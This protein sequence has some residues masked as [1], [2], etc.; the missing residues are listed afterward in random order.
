MMSLDEFMQACFKASKEFGCDEA[1]IYY[2]AENRVMLGVL[3]GNLDNYGVYNES[4]LNL[5]VMYNRRN[6]YAY[7]EVFEDAESL[8]LHAM[9]NAMAIEN[10]DIHPLQ[11]LCAYPEVNEK[12]NPVV[13]MTDEEKLNIVRNLEADIKAFDDRVSRM[14][15]CEINSGVREIRIRNTRGLR[16]DR[17]N[18][19]SYVTVVPIVSQGD[20]ERSSYS[21]KFGPDI[22]DYDDLVKECVDN[23]LILFNAKPV[24]SGEYRVLLRADAASD[25]MERFCEVF[26]AENVQEGLSMLAGK[27]NKSIAS[28]AV[29]IVDDPFEA[30][31]P[32]AFD[33]EGTP[34][35]QTSVVENGVL[36][37][38]LYNLKTARKDGVDSTSNAGRVSPESPVGT[39]PSNFYIKKGERSYKELIS[40]MGRGLII[41]ELGGLHSAVNTVSGDFSLIASG[42]LVEGGSI[43]RSVDQITV[44]GNFITMMQNIIAV[45]NDLRFCLPYQ[46]GRVGSPSLVIDKLTVS[47][48]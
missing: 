7:T 45:G 40:F 36:K 10:D 34:S 35:V 23:A 29:S 17:E 2:A 24:D 38:Y 13:D 4:G 14:S 39:M 37:S 27:L 9:D 41:T 44:A 16:A 18:R 47:G 11:G 8:V 48:K 46:S 30:T 31:Y 20:E 19:Y 28:E 25:F 21:V 42:L 22:T 12:P 5:R 1:E 3:D 32:C 26:F 33:D 6:G 15:R 43:I